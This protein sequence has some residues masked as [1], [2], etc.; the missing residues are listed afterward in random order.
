MEANPVD[1]YS[2]RPATQAD[3]GIIRQIIHEVGINPMALDWERFILATDAEGRVIG[4][5]Q[6]KVHGD[7]SHE[8]ASIA[9]LPEWRGKGIARRIIETLLEQHPGRLYLT[10]QSRLGPL[11]EKFGFQRI[12]LGEMTPYFRRLSRI[13]SIVSKLFR[14]QHIMLV[15]M[16]N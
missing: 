1:N 9:V 10:C 15:M 3:A 7:G 14:Q 2:L 6:V 16:R 4:C 8:L 12:Q 11:Y 5:G 13:V